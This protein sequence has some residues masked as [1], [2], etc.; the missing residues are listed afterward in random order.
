MPP[1]G[2]VT[3]KLGN[4]PL[5]VAIPRDHAPVVLDMAMSQF[6]YG[7]MERLALRGEALP[8]PGGYDADG[9]LTTDPAAILETWR[10]LPT[11]YWKGAGLAMVLDLLAATLSGGLTTREIGAGGEEHAL[12]QVFI[13]IDISR[14][15]G[16]HSVSAVVSAVIEDLH[17]AVAA[18]D[19][20]PARYPGES[21][22]RIRE[23]N[24]R[25]GVPV[26]EQVWEEIRSMGL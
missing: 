10:P 1:W 17:S 7:K 21:V 25:H 12:S 5:I 13:A 23:D 2:T 19:G 20:S 16:P 11:G 3:R 26:D 6:S 14:S 9:Q 4:N 8:L 24:R 18:P 15:A 22:L